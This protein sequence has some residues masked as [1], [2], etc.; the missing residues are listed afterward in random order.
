MPCDCSHLEPTKLEEES[1][2]LAIFIDYVLTKMK[3]FGW[4]TTLEDHEWMKWAKKTAENIYGDT[5][6]V[7]KATEYLCT[8][9][10]NTLSKE[11][12]EDIV[13]DTH[14]RTARGLADWWE[15]HQEVDKEKARV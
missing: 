2:K 7:H 11:E 13:Y 14:S 5:D 8:L 6:K 1:V 12:I 4:Q 3:E 15:D 10:G 9:L